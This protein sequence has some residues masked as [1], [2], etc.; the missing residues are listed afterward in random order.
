MIHRVRWLLAFLFL[1]SSSCI[2]PAPG[3]VK[4][5]PPNRPGS[6]S[7]AVA[8]SSMEAPT[9]TFTPPPTPTPLPA[10]RIHK[11][12]D[13]LFSGDW[14]AALTE[15]QTAL[16]T[17]DDVEI[18]GEAHLGIA[19]SYWMGKKGSESIA[20]LESFIEEYP[21]ARQRPTAHFLLAQA[22]QMQER[23][24]E[25][26]QEF[27]HFLDLKPGAID[28]YIHNFR[29]DLYMLAADYPG[30][31][32]AYQSAL[33]AESVLDDL[34]LQLKLARAFTLSEDFSNALTLYD[35]IFNRTNNDYT[36]ALIDLRKG[37]IYT[38]LGQMDQAYTAYL[39]AVNN[40]PKSY[41]AYTALVELVN[42]GI[43]VDELQRGIV[44]YYARQYGPALA[45]FDHYLQ[46]EPEDPGTAHYYYGQTLAAQ[47]NY[48]AA[49]E[50]WDLLINR[51]D[52]HPL[53]DEGWEMKGYTQWANLEQ[54]DQA[55]QTLSDFAEKK[56][57]HPRA[58]EF[59]YDAAYA[60]ERDQQF[61]RAISLWEKQVSVYP[62]DERS[63]RALFLIGLTYYRMKDF[64]NAA[65]SFQRY[66]GS[67]TILEEKAAGNFWAAK[68]FHSLGDLENAR[69]FWQTAASIDPT[70]YYSERSRDFLHNRD[71]FEFPQSYDLAF[72]LEAER[73]KA[74]EWM[75][76]TFNIPP[77]T[78]LTG[79]ADLVMDPYLRRGLELW[80]LGLYEEARGEFEI[81]RQYAST[82]P[83]KSFR[84]MN[85]FLNLRAY[86]PAVMAARQVLD[87]AG[88]T[89]ATT[90]SAPVFFNHVRFGPYFSEMVLPL[91]QELGFHPLFLFALIRQE[92]LFEGFVSSSAGARGLMQIIPQ[93]G[94]EIAANLGWPED[95]SAEDLYRP[96]INLRLGVNYLDRQR[97][98]FDGN[99]YAALAAYNGGPGN[100]AQWILKAEDDPDLFME[101][102]PYAETRTYI[103]RIYENFMIYKLIYSREQ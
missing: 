30:A 44:D 73:L 84:L 17:T 7:R 28:A 65:N 47:G 97:K 24:V 85:I 96:F 53:W 88:M 51:Y 86:R 42:A 70:G 89:D 87:L 94:A 12:E 102:I 50:Q 18:K 33:A 66:L 8:T 14:E 67:T 76:S 16:A 68:A 13:A 23:F 29:A 49:I 38:T 21:E 52:Q 91:S 74:E 19:R 101:L 59:L 72:D 77:E 95:Y 32:A 10:T 45:A 25:A 4:S 62:D 92:S 78:D 80:E 39:D 41:D 5:N 57:G 40:Y 35:E 15:F 82:D 3:T 34:Q 83:V 31:I 37:Q 27:Q 11:A 26:A 100:A 9:P 58:A 2:R 43:P 6:E 36:R 60:A 46:K 81:T 61:E 75:R 90:L 55:I 98:N 69:S 54:F 63:S 99:L 103:R 48:E 20:Q 93:T 79:P 64:E 71:P 56:P 22:Y 1:L